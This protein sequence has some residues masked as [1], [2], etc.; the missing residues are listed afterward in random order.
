MA[1][2]DLQG[3][4]GGGWSYTAAIC[5]LACA[6]IGMGAILNGLAAHG[7]I[8]PFGATFLTFSDYL[9]PSIRLAA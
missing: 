8:I 4:A 2:G 7:G 9:R 6:N 1:V 5:S 3:S